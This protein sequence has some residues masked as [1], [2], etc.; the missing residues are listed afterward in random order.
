[1]IQRINNLMRKKESNQNLKQKSTTE[2][3]NFV[4]KLNSTFMIAQGKYQ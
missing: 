2:M 3:K 1:M 4:E